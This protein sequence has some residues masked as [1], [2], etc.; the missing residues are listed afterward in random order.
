MDTLHG[1]VEKLS[2]LV[3]ARG[4][5]EVTVNDIE[6][7]SSASAEC[8]TFA[9]NNA[10]TER[11][12]ALAYTALLDLKNKRGDPAIVIKSL[13]DFYNEILTVSAFIED[14]MDKDEIERVMKM[15]PYKLKMCIAATKR[16]RASEV[17]RACERLTEID[18]AS[19]MGGSR[20]YSP[21]EI[22]IA[23]FV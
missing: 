15:H 9:L 12:R 10:L 3:H 16:Y 4:G 1:E 5:T 18:T 17:I 11:N 13:A 7:V 23:E 6:A 8:D 20:G 2:A 21:L 19:K 14:G 22:F